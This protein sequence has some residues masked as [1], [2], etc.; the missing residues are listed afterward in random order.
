LQA[1]QLG[2]NSEVITVDVVDNRDLRH[3]QDWNLKPT[4]E[5]GTSFQLCNFCGELSNWFC[6]RCKSTAY[7]NENCRRANAGKHVEPS[8]MDQLTI[9]LPKN[10]TCFAASQVE[11]TFSEEDKQT[12]LK[13]VREIKLGEIVFDE[14][15]VV[16]MPVAP[17][18]G[19][20]EHRRCLGCHNEVG[21]D[22]KTCR[23]C[24]IGPI[25]STYCKYLI[26][27]YR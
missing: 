18:F 26:I 12:V 14:S 22:W 8:S 9:G 23:M 17:E 2:L 5:P 7:C 16:N 21:G 11:V 3:L 10:S 15:S 4:L 19:S 6:V 25:C 27:V 13:A 20:A 24:G 1:L